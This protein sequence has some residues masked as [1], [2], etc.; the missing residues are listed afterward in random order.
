VEGDDGAKAVVENGDVFSIPKIRWRSVAFPS[1]PGC[2]SVG[3]MEGGAEASRGCHPSIRYR[4]TLHRF[5]P[6]RDSMPHGHVATPRK[7][8]RLSYVATG[9]TITRL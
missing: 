2:D 6:A 9:E 7:T 5:M 4:L 1:A 8:I 3:T